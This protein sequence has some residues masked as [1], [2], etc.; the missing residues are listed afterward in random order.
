MP[1]PAK[2]AVIAFAIILTS[3]AVHQMEDSSKLEAL[4]LNGERLRLA[5]EATAT[6]VFDWDLT[7][8]ECLFSDRF[9]SM[10]GLGPGEG[11]PAVSRAALEAAV[12]DWKREMLREA[13]PAEDRFEREIALRTAGG[14]PIW[15]L[16]S[17][18]VSQRDARGALRRIVGTLSDVT[19]GKLAQQEL[20]RARDLAQQAAQAKAPFLA[21]VSHE[22]RTPL[23]AV[24][25]LSEIL[26]QQGLRPEAAE[27]VD[28]IR[29][30]GEGLMAVVNDILDL[31]RIEA[32]VI[33]LYPEPTELCPYAEQVLLNLLD[34]AIKFTPE[35][36]VGLRLEWTAESATGGTVEF[37]VTDTGIG[38]APEHHARLFEPFSQ[39]DVSATRINGGTGLG[40]SICRGLVERLGGRIGFRSTPGS[41][42]TFW[43]KLPVELAAAGEKGP[44]LPVDR[45]AP[46]FAG[47]RVLVVEDDPVN[48]LVATRL[49]S[50]LGVEAD[51]A[52]DGERAVAAASA[53]AY[54]LILTDIHLPSVDGLQATRAIRVCGRGNP[55][56][57][58]LTARV[59]AEDQA[60][61]LA[62]GMNGFLPKPL[63]L[64][65]LRDVLAG[66]AADRA[67]GAS[68]GASA[69][70]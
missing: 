13:V 53:G 66:V 52:E 23:S 56:V 58:A 4:R 44:P 16:V 27:L 28:L 7:S 2:F 11:P 30:S 17:A 47:L 50:R 70:R 38:I 19:A 46:S 57:V 33:P 59:S 54:D 34:N 69:T 37:S 41:G 5:L 65:S 35:G 18:T 25:G 9:R 26:G 36:E 62:A 61:C 31:S 32:G 22:I 43:F 40:L 45:P 10:L 64:D 21:N 1:A 6:A 42:S 14:D 15:L 20:N 60:E 48:R 67:A 68:A 24:V 55:R 12:S 63:R 39:V 51:T 49:L 3:L 29:S 8:D